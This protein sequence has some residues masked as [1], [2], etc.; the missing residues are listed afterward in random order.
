[1]RK[2]FT[3]LCLFFLA[4]GLWGVKTEETYTPKPIHVLCYHDIT[5]NSSFKYSRTPEKLK[6]DFQLLKDSGFKIV[7]LEKIIEAGQKKVPLALREVV[8]TFDDATTGQY[9]Y[10][11]PLLKSHGYPAAFYVPTAMVESGLPVVKEYN[12]TMSWPDIQKLAEEGFFIASHGHSH[13]DLSRLSPVD[14]KEEIKKSMY[15]LRER[16][17]INALDFCLPYGLYKREQEEYFLEVGIRSMALTT[18][19]HGPGNP[20]LAKIRRFEVLAD[21]SGEEILEA[22]GGEKREKMP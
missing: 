13:K 10:A 6:H 16:A 2:L 22:L 9:Q 20:A 4:F 8:I 7:P 12:G 1:M 15:L 11:R 19:D 18:T 17:G 3:F 5:P 14:L 21:T